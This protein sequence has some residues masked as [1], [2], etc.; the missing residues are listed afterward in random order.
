MELKRQ[1]KKHQLALSHLSDGDDF[2][3]I[4]FTF[5]AEEIVDRNQ[6]VWVL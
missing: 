5:L 6:D 2:F 4:H 3:E 1:T